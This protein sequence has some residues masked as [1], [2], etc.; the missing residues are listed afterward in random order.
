MLLNFETNEYKLLQPVIMA[1]TELLPRIKR[2]HNLMDRI[3]LKYTI[4]PLDEEETRQI[5]F[6]RLKAAGSSRPEELFRPEAV[7]LIYQY[8]RGY[9]R[10]IAMLC[11][12]ALEQLV[13]RDEPCVN[14]EIVGSLIAR[15]ITL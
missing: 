14:E 7:K 3:S 8:T 2:V 5:I 9:P 12:D 10:K 11:H 1:Q 15:E 13:M 4:N 6:F